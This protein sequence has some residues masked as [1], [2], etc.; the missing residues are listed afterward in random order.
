MDLPPIT[1]LV[2]Y[3]NDPQ[4]TIPFGP[5]T[6]SDLACLY[7]V[8]YTV[9]YSLHGDPISE[10]YFVS[11]DAASQ[12]TVEAFLPDAIEVYDIIVTATI[13]QPSDPSGIK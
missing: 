6:W 2:Y 13:D 8:V 12:F 9:E 3:L 4:A 10:P 1:D 5:A 7:D 11:F